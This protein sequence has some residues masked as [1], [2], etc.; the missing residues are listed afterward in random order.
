MDNY[1]EVPIEIYDKD[2]VA[3]WTYKGWYAVESEKH[4]GVIALVNSAELADVIVRALNA[5]G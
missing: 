2:V 1:V 4:G 3:E 5:E